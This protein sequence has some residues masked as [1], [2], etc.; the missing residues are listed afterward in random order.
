MKSFLKQSI[1]S[2]DDNISVENGSADR[3]IVQ[4]RQLRDAGIPVARL[5][6]EEAAASQGC[7][8][9]IFEYIPNAYQL[10]WP[11]NAT[12][13][14]N[15]ELRIIYDLFHL[16]AQHE[17]DIDIRPSNLRRRA[18]GRVVVVD[19]LE[20]PP[21]KGFKLYLNL[22]NRIATFCQKGDS[23]YNRLITA[24]ASLKPPAT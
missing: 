6:N 1:L 8:Y 21:K 22:V 15:Q 13:E 10:T 17:L 16:A 9:F 18:D 14:N 5:Y 12:I 24:I 4:H 20:S 2:R 23:I 7:G 11:P 3:V 19:F